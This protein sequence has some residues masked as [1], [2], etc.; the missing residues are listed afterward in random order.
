MHHAALEQRLDTVEGKLDG[1]LTKETSTCEAGAHEL[2]DLTVGKSLTRGARKP[3]RRDTSA[4]S[5]GR[6]RATGGPAATGSSP[7]DA[8]HVLEWAVDRV[9]AS[10]HADGPAAWHAYCREHG[11]ASFDPARHSAAF[12]EDFLH[13]LRDSPPAALRSAH[14]P[15]L[16]PARPAAGQP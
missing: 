11:K 3:V 13:R 8:P 15:R 2:K 7:V 6:H 10:Q 12:L 4:P 14:P 16:S 1:E 5:G 9:K